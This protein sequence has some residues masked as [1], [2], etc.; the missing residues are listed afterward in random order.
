MEKKWLLIVLIA[1]SIFG[2]TEKPERVPIETPETKQ[3]IE[4]FKTLSEFGLTQY[5]NGLNYLVIAN[6]SFKDHKII[7]AW[8]NFDKAEE[9]MQDAENNFSLSILKVQSPNLINFTKYMS[10]N[11]NYKLKAI[12]AYKEA[13]HLIDTENRPNDFISVLVKS[14]NDFYNKSLEYR[15][16]ALM[17]YPKAF[18]FMYPEP[19]IKISPFLIRKEFNLFGNESTIFETYTLKP[20]SFQTLYFYFNISD[21]EEFE[22]SGTIFSSQ[23]EPSEVRTANF[24]ISMKEIDF[25]ILD[26]NNYQKWEEWWR[27][28]YGRGISYG[29]QLDYQKIGIEK[30]YFYGTVKGGFID[31]S[32]KPDKTGRYYFILDNGF[33]ASEKQAKIKGLISYQYYS[34]K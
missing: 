6:N 24:Y 17:S 25:Y 28:S 1:I 11:C 19:I 10:L 4:E 32:F 29:G 14:G 7:E 2:C 5:N 34:H 16:N 18:N 13:I 26:E 30:A 33:S 12:K 9:L 8:W 20:Y 22:I 21:L 23:E 3:L 31:Y 15:Q 27:K